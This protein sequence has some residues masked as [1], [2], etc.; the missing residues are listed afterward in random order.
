MSAAHGHVIPRPD[1][2]KARCGGPALC[3][4]CAAELDQVQ[5]KET[6][7]AALLSLA[8]ELDRRGA[9]SPPDAQRAAFLASAA[10]A[11]QRAGGSSSEGNEAAPVSREGQE[12]SSDL[13]PAQAYMAGVKAERERIA[14]LADRNG[15]VCTGDE[16]TS[17]YFSALIREVP[18]DGS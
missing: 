17:C 16:G 5:R 2:A 6:A 13:T 12:P 15:A 18:G 10:V 11:R 7:T 8:A 4:V 14:Q 3:S 9:A 1:G